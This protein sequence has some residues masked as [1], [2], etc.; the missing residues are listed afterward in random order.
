MTKVELR[1]AFLAQRIA[2]P[3]GDV[4]RRSQLIAEQFFTYFKAERLADIPSFVHSF[5]PIRRYNE[6]DTWP[7]IKGIWT[8][9]DHMAISVPVTD[10]A[11]RQMRHC[12]I[13]PDTL[14]VENSIGIPEPA[15]DSRYETDLKYIIAVIVPLLAFDKR[16]HR[17]GYGGGYYDRFGSERVPNSRKIGLSLFDPVEEIDDIE[18]T[19][20]PLD[21]C[22]TPTR[23]WHFSK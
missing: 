18:P 2:L 6:V 4:E 10:Q 1:R 15:V 7:I 23:I 3:V 21:V 16:G 9:F 5:L 8:T 12:T 19:D 20:V 11:T 14:I 17:V 22:I 13:F